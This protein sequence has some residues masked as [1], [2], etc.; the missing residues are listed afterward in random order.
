MTWKTIWT[1]EENRYK[2]VQLTELRDR[3]DI[4]QRFRMQIGSWVSGKLVETDCDVSLEDLGRLKY[5]LNSI[6]LEEV[7]E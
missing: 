1:G 7:S 5:F 2:L 4:L 3:R 6:D